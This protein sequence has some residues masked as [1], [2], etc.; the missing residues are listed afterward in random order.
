MR[1]EATAAELYR[2]WIRPGDLV[3]DI[4]A[5]SGGHT[6]VFLDLGARVVAIE[7]QADEAAHIDRRADILELAVSSRVGYATMRRASHQTYMT[8][9]QHDYPDRV[10]AHAEI[11]YDETFQVGT[12]TLDELVRVYGPPSFCKIDVEGHEESVL[13]G[14]STPL[15][16]LSLELHDFA[17]EKR[18]RCVYMLHSLHPG[19][20]F[21]YS[22]RESFLFEPGVPERLDMFGD[23][24][25]W[26]P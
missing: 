21:G 14:L 17:P 9:M 25:A 13:R 12:V 4:G 3:F 26:L 1:E 11:D 22:R 24:Y 10:Q 23:L 2:R 16:A 6:L 20:L 15:P 8:T 18:D 7:P 5:H 19:Y